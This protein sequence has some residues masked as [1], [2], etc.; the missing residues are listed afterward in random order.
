[1]LFTKH[2]SIKMNLNY[3]DVK[4]WELKKGQ[5]RIHEVQYIISSGLF[6]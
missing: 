6:F 3:R 2:D 4:T 5:C 1:M